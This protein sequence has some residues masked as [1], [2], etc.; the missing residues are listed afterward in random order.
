MEGRER[1]QRGVEAQNE[2]SVEQWL[3]IRIK[4]KSLIRIRIEVKSRIG[5]P[6]QHLSDADQQPC[7]WIMMAS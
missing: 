4:V 2:G 7:F 6:D 5:G 3:R 1:S